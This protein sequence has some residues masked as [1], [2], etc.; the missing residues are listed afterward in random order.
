[1]KKIFALFVLIGFL[2]LTPAEEKKEQYIPKSTDGVLDSIRNNEKIFWYDKETMPSL[3]Q[4]WRPSSN[5][6]FYFGIV[7]SKENISANRSEPFGNANREFPWLA[8]AGVTTQTPVKHFAIIP[9]PAKMKWADRGKY[10]RVLEWTYQTDTI[11][12]EVILVKS[13]EGKLIP[14]EVR[15]RHKTANGWEATA[16]RPFAT[17]KDLLA[18]CQNIPVE[19]SDKLSKALVK[20][21]AK[22]FA[23]R[24]PH[25]DKVTF[26]AKGTWEFLPEIS[27][28]SVVKLLDRPFEDSHSAVW[29]ESDPPC[30][31]PTTKAEF[32]IVPKDYDAAGVRVSTRSCNRCHETTLQSVDDFQKER[33]WYGHVRGSDTI[34]TFHPFDPAIANVRHLNDR[35][36]V[37]NEKFIGKFFEMESK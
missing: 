26:E 16:Y 15:I 7:P 2:G 21:D 9:K 19:D 28:R 20:P 11:F 6:G 34:F 25:P 36:K 33:D 23:I 1:M 35:N 32:H 5:T 12:G 37:F 31:A 22:V 8:T 17:Y 4:E 29:R 14:C 13:P 30:H 27:P 3:F 10:G 24:S 18:A